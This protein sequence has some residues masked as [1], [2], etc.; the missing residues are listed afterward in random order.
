MF[1]TRRGRAAW[2]SVDCTRL[3]SRRHDARAL[4]T[5]REGPPLDAAAGRGS[6]K[7]GRSR[8]QESGRRWVFIFIGRRRAAVAVWPGPTCALPS[9]L[10]RLHRRQLHVMCSVGLR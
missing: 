9:T 4:T 7:R 6:Q 8:T 10:Y 5:L 3:Y 2:Y 1:S